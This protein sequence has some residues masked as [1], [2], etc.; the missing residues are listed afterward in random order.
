M[1]N[2]I[3][4]IP[5]SCEVIENKSA[6]FTFNTLFE[7]NKLWQFAPWKLIGLSWQAA[8]NSD[9]NDPALMQIRL[10][11]SQ[12]SNIQA[13]SSTRCIVTPGSVRSGYIK[14]RNPNPWKEDEEKTQTLIE[15]D[16]VQIGSDAVPSK[17]FLLGVARF[18]IGPLPFTTP[19]SVKKY[20]LVDSPFNRVTTPSQGSSSPF[21]EPF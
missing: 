1:S 6:E 4:N 7:D 16:N 8:R 15:I 5:L 14:S 11:S 17:L 9:V 18:L 21:T 19:A 3:V 2:Q 10:N 20:R 12:K 13:I